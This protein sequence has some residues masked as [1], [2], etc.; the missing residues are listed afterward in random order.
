[1][2][3]VLAS[4]SEDP[5]FVPEPPTSATPGL[6]TAT[7]EEEIDE[8]FARLPESD[9]TDAVAGRADELR[10]L[11][12][13]IAPALLHGRLIR[14]HGDLHLGQVLRSGSEWFVT[15]FEGEPDRSIAD[16][17]RKSM[18]L[19]DV[20]GMLRSFSYLV[21]ALA[22]DGRAAPA[23]VEEEARARFLAGYRAAIDPQLVP[24]EQQQDRILDLFELEKAVYEVRYELAHRPD[25][26][27]VPVAGLL[28]FLERAAT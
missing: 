20:A 12:R 22:R 2:H 10:E 21:A 23:H 1:M 7:I 11:V 16:R 8:V 13:G 24:A 14:T 5:A 17:R 18:P 4:D 15:D 9:A 3:D 6:V 26:V 28:R 27:D 25:W 19:R